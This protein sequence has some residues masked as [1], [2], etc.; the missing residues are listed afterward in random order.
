MTGGSSRKAA[1]GAEKEI[2]VLLGFGESCKSLG[3]LC[4]FA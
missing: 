2:F 3:V 1:E 4:A